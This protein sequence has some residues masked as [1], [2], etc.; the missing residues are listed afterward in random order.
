VTTA[1]EPQPVPPPQPPGTPSPGTHRVL[2]RSRDDRVVA[3][4]CGGL[5]RYLGVDSVLLRIAFVILAVLGGSGILLYLL[6]WIVLPEE[7]PGD[8]LGA[9]APSQASAGAFRLIVGGGLIALGAALLA[10][11][12][13]PGW[14]DDKYVWPLVLIVIGIAVLTRGPRG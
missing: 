4:V 1:D 9:A 14:I 6:A 10:D 3:G 11:R 7:R 12:I 2:R 13:L 5:G 8:E